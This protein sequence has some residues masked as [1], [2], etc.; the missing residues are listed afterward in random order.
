MN[1]KLITEFNGEARTELVEASNGK[2]DWFIEGIFM[3]SEVKNRN[4]RIYPKEILE[5]EVQRYDREYVKTNRALGELNHPSSPVVNPE[6]ASHLITEMS[7][8]GNDFYGKAKILHTPMGDI[9]RGLLESGVQIGV[10]SRGMGSLKESNGVNIVQPDFKLGCVDVVADPS[11]PSAF[12]NGIMEGVE[13]VMDNGVI[14]EQKIE[15]IKHDL[16][17]MV[18]AKTIAEAEIK[19]FTS[20]MNELT[21]V[22]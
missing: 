19:A 5:R 13:W 9:V 2:K 15:Q 10:S 22:K 20:F 1:M 3:Q 11:A 8:S 7:Q 21:K 17:N 6:R 4:G 18:D 12:V 14:K 16:D